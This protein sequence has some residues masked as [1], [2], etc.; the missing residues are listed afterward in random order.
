MALLTFVSGAIIIIIIIDNI[1]TIVIVIPIYIV[2]VIVTTIIIII[3]NVVV[4]NIILHARW[5]HVPHNFA[6]FEVQV[7]KNTNKRSLSIFGKL[8]IKLFRH[9]TL[10]QFDFKLCVSYKIYR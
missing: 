6:G 3:V 7:Q 9:V 4:I 2:I 1:I 5:H 8:I 10:R